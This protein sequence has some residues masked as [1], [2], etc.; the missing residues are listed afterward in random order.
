[1][2]SRCRIATWRTVRTLAGR[3]LRLH[4]WSWCDSVQ[5][6][7]D[8]AGAQFGGDV[9]PQVGLRPAFDALDAEAAVGDPGA[10]LL[11]GRLKLVGDGADDGNGGVTAA[12]HACTSVP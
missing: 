5:L 11:L 2:R 4:R 9:Q 6:D 7:L 1:I 10:C 8:G 3:P 12:D